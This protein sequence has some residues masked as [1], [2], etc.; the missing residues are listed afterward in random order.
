M[1][2]RDSL[3]LH[4][5]AQRQI[6]MRETRTRTRIEG[7]SGTFHPLLPGIAD[8][9][10]QEHEMPQVVRA[11]QRGP[12]SEQIRTGDGEANGRKERVDAQSRRLGLPIADVDID[13]ITGEI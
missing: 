9:V 7:C 6:A 1:G 12:P 4:S 2:E 11:S 8:F 10:V 13:A 5:G 3:A